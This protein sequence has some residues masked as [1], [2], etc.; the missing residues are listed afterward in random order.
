MIERVLLVLFLIG[1]IISA[2]FFLH[3]PLREELAARPSPAVAIQPSPAGPSQLEVFVKRLMAYPL[4]GEPS[5]EEIQLLPGQLPEELP[6][7]LPLLENA[8]VVGSLVRGSTDGVIILDV[9]QDPGSVRDFYRREL[10]AHGWEELRL[11]REGL[12]GFVSPLLLS[13]LGF[14]RGREGPH[15]SV[16]TQPRNELTEVRLS[17][18]LDPTRSPCDQPPFVIQPGFT[19]PQQVL[20][21][22]IAPKNAW[23]LSG[24]GGGGESGAY[25]HV[26]L[27]TSASLRELWEH[28]ARQLREQ[29]WELIQ[30]GESGP[31]VWGRW[32]FEREG[33]RWEGLL[34]VL[35]L[36]GERRFAYV[37]VDL[38]GER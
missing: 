16:L 34:F 31:L 27:K 21:T 37:R 36:G 14:C 12:K 25:R 20:P 19:G 32:R 17:W 26:I 11:T 33:Q 13:S 15:L 1:V 8:H 10:T 24:G 5:P 38:T 22:L 3:L 2:G 35:D 29:G 6:F 18:T 28:Y 7:E 4:P 30:R 9:P 23:Q